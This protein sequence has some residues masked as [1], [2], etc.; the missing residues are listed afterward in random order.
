[1]QLIEIAWLQL[2]GFRLK[3]RYVAPA[4]WT[5]LHKLTHDPHHMHFMSLEWDVNA[6]L[7]EQTQ[8]Y[9]SKT[10]RPICPFTPVFV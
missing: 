5:H 10:M 7:K 6:R 1:M 3:R 9:A 2:L 8:P 4:V